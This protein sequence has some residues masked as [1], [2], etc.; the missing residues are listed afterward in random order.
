V[1]AEIGPSTV[2]K[3]PKEMLN[4]DKLPK[5]MNKTSKKAI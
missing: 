3:K 1:V 4:Q 5:V 2:D